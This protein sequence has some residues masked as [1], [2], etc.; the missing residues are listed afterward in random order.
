MTTTPNITCCLTS[1][2]RYDLL[3]KTLESFFRYNTYPIQEFIISED[4]DFEGT[5]MDYIVK[6]FRKYAPKDMELRLMFGKV[7]QIRS[8]DRMYEKVET[9]Y[10]FHMEDDFLFFRE[11]FIEKSIEILECDPKLF[12]VHLREQDDLN[13]HKVVAFSDKY[14]LLE[15]GCANGWSGFSLNSGLRKTADYKLVGNGG[16]ASIGHELQLAKYFYEVHGLIAAITK[17]GY[18]R[19]IGGGRTVRDTVRVK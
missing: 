8:I 2:G 6:M 9:E 18:V 14:D 3:E 7:G 5:V 11:G 10:I 19:H 15:Y 1:C 12:Q 13:G 17:T 4:S 16:Y